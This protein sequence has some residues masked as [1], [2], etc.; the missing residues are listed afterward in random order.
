LRSGSH[1]PPIAINSAAVGQQVFLWS[2][3]ATALAILTVR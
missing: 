1:I 2:R 3:P